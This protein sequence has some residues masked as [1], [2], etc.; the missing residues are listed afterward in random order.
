[1]QVDP[2]PSGRRCI[3]AWGAAPPSDAMVLVNALFLAN[4]TA[5]GES[6]GRPLRGPGAPGSD[7]KT[8]RPP[9]KLCGFRC[10]DGGNYRTQR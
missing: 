3:E 9:V 10:R 1:M 8:A 6:C 4:A 5:P 2:W 7:P